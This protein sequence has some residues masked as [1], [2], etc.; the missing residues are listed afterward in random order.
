MIGLGLKPGEA[1][2]DEAR[3]TIRRRAAG[4]ERPS[5]IA[6]VLGLSVRT[7]YRVIAQSGGVP[8]RSRSDSR[9]YLSLPD[10]EQ[11]GLGLARGDTFQV[12]AAGV[13]RHPS[14]VGREVARHGG[15]HGYQAWRAQRDAHERAK[16]PKREK[17]AQNPQ[18]LA[19]VEFMLEQH[20]S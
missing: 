18:L 20:Y 19:A 17:L 15:R 13:G 6:A 4:G 11:I 16:R 7:I 3:L 10:R 5:V 14:T 1:L 8:P 12:I 9:V 2:P